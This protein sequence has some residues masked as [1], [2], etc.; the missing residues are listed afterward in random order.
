VV[1]VVRKI[2]LDFMHKKGVSRIE[3][4]TDDT[5]LTMAF[6]LAKSGRTGKTELKSL[7]PVSIPYWVVQVSD[8]SSILLSAM[9]EAPT[10]LELS[11]DTAIGP[12]R[13]ILSNE[14]TSM[15]MIPQA[16]EKAIPLLKTTEPIV[17]TI[18]NLQEPSLFTSLGH[19]FREVDP[20]EELN[21]IELKIDSQ[22]ALEISQRYQAII[23][24]ATTR[25]RN[26]ED[27][28]KLSKE[29]LSDQ[30]TVLDNVNQSEMARW[31]KRYE[32]NEASS[33][34][35]MQKLTER[36]SDIE[37]QLKEKRNR[38]NQS[39]ASK[40][41]HDTAEI[42]KFFNQVLIEIKTLRSEMGYRGE[43]IESV[44]Q[45]YRTLSSYLS[46]TLPALK[47]VTN[48]LDDRT[49]EILKGA[50]DLD[51]EMEESIRKEHMAVDEEIRD[52]QQMLQD[53]KEEKEKKEVELR[54][55]MTV[56][57]TAVEAF[58]D[59]IEARVSELQSDLQKLASFTLENNAIN[60][61][62]PLTLLN[63]KTYAAVYSRGQPI[64][65]PPIF[66]PEDRI[67]IPYNQNP[68]DVSFEKYIQKS[69]LNLYKNSP[70]FKT[71]FGQTSMSG[72]IFGNPEIT[73]PFSKGLKIL[74][75]DQL[76]KDGAL[77]SIEA[78][79]MKHVGKCPECQAEIG[80]LSKF[81]PECGATIS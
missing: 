13:R 60:H 26:M 63:V 31:N 33:E 56:V 7:T 8:R 70:S 4:V 69:V 10:S 16:V 17:H 73:Q 54:D 20:G 53:L 36:K 65:F 35:K 38:D 49:D 71:T 68:L 72:N 2:A 80:Q 55:Q 29:R 22:D 5:A 28:R 58:D 51:H 1:V 62:T 12:V 18:S 6:I 32:T 59:V 67:G 15:D 23:Q 66:I 40:F 50:L 81:C 74:F 46:D 52:L 42:E 44:V 3:A 48:G 21:T 14:T 78:L 61:L 57:T 75:T 37:Y 77:E 79:F 25:L 39:I 11:E 76:L 24:A 64:V 45:K 43:N 27:L 9:G 30:L 41:V 47:E 34:Y 19:Y